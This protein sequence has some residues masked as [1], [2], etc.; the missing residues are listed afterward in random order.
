MNLMVRELYLALPM[1]S[2]SRH[3]AVL[4]FCLSVLVSRFGHQFIGFGTAFDYTRFDAAGA[5][6][7]WVAGDLKKVVLAQRFPDRFLGRHEPL[8]QKGIARHSETHLAG[9]L[10]VNRRRLSTNQPYHVISQQGRP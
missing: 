7:D 5:I 6:A 9:K 1:A 10:I 4:C 2:L 3:C 8:R